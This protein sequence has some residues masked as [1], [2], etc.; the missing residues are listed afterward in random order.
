[1]LVFVQFGTVFKYYV[2][3]RTSPFHT[4]YRRRNR[5][6][7]SGARFRSRLFLRHGF[8]AG[9]I[10]SFTEGCERLRQLGREV[11]IIDDVRLAVDIRIVVAGEPYRALDVRQVS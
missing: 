6:L 8:G 5:A 10:D 3:R 1:M 9:G 11:K 2:M 7:P 4:G